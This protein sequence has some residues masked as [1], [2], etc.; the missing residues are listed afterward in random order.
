[1]GLAI[2]EGEELKLSHV[3]QARLEVGQGSNR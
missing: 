2:A 1:M 3:G